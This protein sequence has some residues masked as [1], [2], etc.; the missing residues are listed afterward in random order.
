[1]LA[2]LAACPAGAQTRDGFYKDKTITLIVGI[3]PGG[4][5]DQYARLLARHLPQ[6][7]AGAPTIIVRNLPGAGSLNSVLNL[8]RIAP[9][10]GTQIGTFNIGLLTEAVTK[11]DAARVKFN[12]FAWVGSM[13]RDLRVCVASKKSKIQTWDDLKSGKPAIF[14]AAGADS[15]SAN[16]I[17]A[18]RNLFNLTNL[19]AITGYPGLTETN[20]A[21]ERGEVD[22]T[23]ASWIAIPESWIRNKEVNVL[24]RL[25]PNTAPEIPDSA[26]FI[27]DI[28]DTIEKKALVDVLA[29]PGELARPFIMSDKVPPERVAVIRK[30]FA[31]TL[32]DPD[33]LADAERVKLPINLVDGIA[34]QAIVERLYALAPDVAEKARAVLD[35]G[36]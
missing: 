13:T 19:K 17:A 36:P 27:G 23:C 34:A 9:A 3:T 5:Y 8:A 20:L 10:D 1:M 22:G 25:S 29:S 21:V 11:R 4:G 18:I 31:E 12:E 7:I 26:K 6:H 15:N 28:A 30:A 35:I 24:V 32:A 14:G 33:F 2:A 16:G